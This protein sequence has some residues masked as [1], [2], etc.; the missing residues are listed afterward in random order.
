MSRKRTE[1]EKEKEQNTGCS[2][3]LIPDNGDPIRSFKTSLNKIV[4][5]IV[6]LSAVFLIL[7]CYCIFSTIMIKQGVITPK[8]TAEELPD[9]QALQEENMQLKEQNAE[10]ATRVSTLGTE[11]AALEKESQVADVNKEEQSI[12]TGFPMDGTA[13][14]ENTQE[15]DATNPVTFSGPVATAIKAAG[16]GV[17]KDI[18][19]DAVAGNI[20]TIDHQNGYETVYTTNANLRIKEGDE[21]KKGDI[22]CIIAVDG[23]RLIYQIKKDGSFIDPMSMMEIAG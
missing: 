13:S 21:V 3:M 20:I 23:E 19:T 5:I 9:V 12:P 17:V 22:I 2:V 14:L 11:L 16:T 4:T 7:I 10:Y 6:T 8:A 1:E 15:D 18:T